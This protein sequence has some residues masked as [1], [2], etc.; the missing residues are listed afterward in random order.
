MLLV[1]TQVKDLHALLAAGDARQLPGDTYAK[2]PRSKAG[3]GRA[4]M[5]FGCSYEY[6]EGKGFESGI[7]PARSVGEMPLCLQALVQRLVATGVLPK[8]LVPDSAIVNAYAAGDCIPPHGNMFYF[9][10]S[11]VVLGTAIYVGAK[12]LV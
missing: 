1:Y 6:R 3:N 7:K 2:P 5:Q 4:T 12:V 8:A 10:S 9:Q 11:F